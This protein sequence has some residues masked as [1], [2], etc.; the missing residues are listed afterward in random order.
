[1]N[2]G[3]YSNLQTAHPMW[4]PAAVQAAQQGHAKGLHRPLGYEGLAYTLHR[5]CKPDGAIYWSL[6]YRFGRDGKQKT[7]AS[8]V[9]DWLPE[10]PPKDC[11]QKISP[12]AHPI[13]ITSDG[14]DYMARVVL[15]A[16]G[17]PLPV[18]IGAQL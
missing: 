15:D 12:P 11:R 5:F 7:I 1:M 9:T 3:E 13:R 17:Q 4:I 10:K 18:P 2:N 6:S 8:W 14:C 16:T